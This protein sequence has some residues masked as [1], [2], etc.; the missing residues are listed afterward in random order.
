M[1]GPELRYDDPGSTAAAV[2]LLRRHDGQEPEANITSAVRDFLTATGLTKP[3]EIVEENPPSDSSRQVVDLTTLDTFL[4]LKQRIGT[5]GNPHPDHVAQLD[6]YLKQ[7]EDA[8]RVRMGILTNGKHWLLRWPQAGPVR[9]VPPY[10]FTLDSGERWFRLYEWLKSQ[11]FTA[12]DNIPPDRSS[13][14][15]HF[16]PDA[17]YSRGGPD[18][19]ADGRA[20]RPPHLPDRRDRISYEPTRIPKLQRMRI[21]HMAHAEFFGDAFQYTHRGLLH[22]VAGPDEWIVHPMLFRSQDD[23]KVTPPIDVSSS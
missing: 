14:A 7:S 19:R 21:A 13:L 8:G 10:L 12:L 5:H 11:A 17:P 18:T 23:C 6:G 22:A 1:T 15:E 3:E 4:E 9:T 20:L 2:E 16:G